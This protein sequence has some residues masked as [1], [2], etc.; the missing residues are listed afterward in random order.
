VLIEITQG[1]RESF[2]R[3]LFLM[4]SVEPRAF[5]GSLKERDRFHMVPDK[6]DRWRFASAG[7]GSE[8]ATQ[9][10]PTGDRQSLR[11]G[12]SYLRSLSFFVIAW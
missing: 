12:P 4:L 5:G 8:T 2:M 6:S 9:R 10:L 1:R 7:R 3:V 11:G